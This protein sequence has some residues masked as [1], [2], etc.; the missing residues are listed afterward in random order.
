MKQ[1]LPRV[2][3]DLEKL[4]HINC[5][6]GRF[7]LHLAEALLRESE[8]SFEPVFFLSPGT[9]RHL[10]AAGF[11]R[12]AVAPWRKEA[13]VRFVRPLAR[14]F[15]P[16]PRVDLWHV[17]NQLSKY[18]PLDPRVPVLLTI[19]DLA[20]L[21]ENPPGDSP[22]R[23]ARKLA[24]IQA[25]IDR[26]SVVVTDSRFVADDVVRHLR[27]GDRP[28]HVVPLGLAPATA[29]APRRPAGVP[30]GPFLL[31]VGNCLRH[32]NFHVLLDMLEALPARRL[33]IAG[34]KT[35]P[36]G[37]FLQREV[38]RRDLGDRATL[39]GEVTDADRQWLYAHAEG[40]LFPSLTEGFG[41]PVLE[42]M[43]AG[44]PVFT[45]RVTCLPEIVGQH[46]FYFES[47]AGPALAA[48]VEAGL[49]SF[50]ADPGFAARA[51]AHAAGFS[52]QATAR[53]YGRVYARMLA[54]AAAENGIPTRLPAC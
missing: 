21:H 37:E 10:P 26:A 52:W 39:L 12:I 18:L 31:S 6:L 16:A 19:H 30:P 40:F 3:I 36:Y 22:R 1:P 20:F 44:L 47:F 42:A 9:E 11:E 50:A 24:D 32:K 38:A 8:G 43:Q 41:F 46:G 4:R 17:T 54:A 5:G 53:E 27:L 29:A 15:L 51:R 48:V 49:R 7:S 28:L 35:T 23:Q 25:K 14:P 13:F 33:V 45:S 34:K 2:V